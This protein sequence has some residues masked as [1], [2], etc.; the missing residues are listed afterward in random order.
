MK[1][2]PVFA[3]NLLLWYP[4]QPLMA[5]HAG[6]P[7]FK[8]EPPSSVPM[9]IPATKLFQKIKVNLPNLHLQQIS[10]ICEILFFKLLKW[11]GRR[12]GM[13]K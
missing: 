12:L 8:Q 10:R 1:K 5:A 9:W 3:L 2:A 13:A 6:P 4:L 11:G 7:S